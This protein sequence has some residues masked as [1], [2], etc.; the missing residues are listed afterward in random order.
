MSSQE[1]GDRKEAKRFD[2]DIVESLKAYYKIEDSDD[3]DLYRFIKH[4]RTIPD[5]D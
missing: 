5:E 3:K 2:D 1:P 4:H